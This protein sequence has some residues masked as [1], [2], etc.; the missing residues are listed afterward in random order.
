MTVLILTCE[1][2]VTADMVVAR[3]HETGT[4]VMR[5]DP[6]DLPGKA[7][8][9]AEYAHGDFDGH[10]SVNGHV[11]STGALRSVWVRRPGEPAAHAA[12]PSPWLTAETGQAL[13]GMLHCVPTRWMNHPRSAEQARLKPAQL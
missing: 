4:P 9:S 13:Y 6:A 2:D 8:L 1:E 3:L 5:L 7:M 10:L 11:L 12:H